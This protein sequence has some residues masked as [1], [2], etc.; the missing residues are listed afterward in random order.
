MANSSIWPRDEI[1]SGAVTLGQSGPG[2]NGNEG[3]SHIPQIDKAGALLS[4]DLIYP[5]HF[6]G[7]SYL[8]AKMQ[9][10]YSTAPADLR[11]RMCVYIYI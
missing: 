5:G 9:L 11:M 1:L 2:S 6:L 8:C 7:G 4:D 3:V 10:V